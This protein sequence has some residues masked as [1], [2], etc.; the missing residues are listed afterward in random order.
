M[1]FVIARQAIFDQQ[2]EVF[3]YEVYLRKSEDLDHYPEDVP[4]NKATFIVAE[5]IAEIGMK[6]VADGKKVFMNVTLDSV[7]NKVLDL[8][9]PER[10][11]FEIIPSKT[12]LG[13]SIYQNVLKRIDELKSNGATITLN[14]GLYSS[15]YIDLV[16]RANIIEMQAP[17]CEEN[18]IL[19]A[20]R[21]NKKV[22]IS[23]IESESQYSKVKAIADYFEGNYLQKP[24]IIKEFEIAPFL[25]T[26]LLRMISALNTAQSIRDF[27]NIISSDV[28]MSAKL[29]RFVNSAYF[30]H[31]KEIKDIIQ[32]CSYLGMENLKKFTLLVATNDYVTVENPELWKKSLIRATICEEIARK[33][34]P[35]L[36]NEAY[37]VGLFSL[38]DEILHVDKVEFLKEVNVDQV[39]I[40]AFTGN[41]PTLEEFLRMAISLETALS[42]G[43]EEKVNNVIATVAQK[44]GMQPFELK[45][46]LLDAMTKAEEVLRL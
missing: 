15:R 7:L 40:D 6:R 1:S 3:G 20:K 18:K 17:K 43:E 2:G 19:G 46:K 29:L 31:R 41:N 39:I 35:E 4:F 44:L 24:S 21:N 36:S 13:Q 8:L 25:K 45:N 16:E 27:A 5:L 38:I 12:E 30:A 26:T 42:E 22:L 28:G 11:V 14:D 23:K 10:M 32:A 37:L 9:T 33:L 34:K